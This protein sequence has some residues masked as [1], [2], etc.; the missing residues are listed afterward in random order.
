MIKKLGC[1]S[2]AAAMTLTMSFGLVQVAD[3]A[4]FPVI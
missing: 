1:L 4:G 3:P 2:M